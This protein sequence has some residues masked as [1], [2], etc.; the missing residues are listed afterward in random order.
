[1]DID[2]VRPDDVLFYIN[3]NEGG[4]VFDENSIRR[5]IDKHNP[6]NRDP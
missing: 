2:D 6:D 4:I 3:P 5:W 1:M